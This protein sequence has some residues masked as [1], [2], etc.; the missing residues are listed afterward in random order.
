MARKIGNLV[1]PTGKYIKDGEEKTSWMRVGVL[2]ETDKGL[3]I[4]LDAIP[5]VT[6]DNGLWLSVFEEDS[7]PRQ[8]AQPAQQPQQA[9]APSQPDVPF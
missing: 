4:K 3:R 1:F 2:I 8:Q 6:G 7:N 5:V 9:A